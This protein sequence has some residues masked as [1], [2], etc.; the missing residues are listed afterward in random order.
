MEVS[1]PGDFPRLPCTPADQGRAPHSYNP[2]HVRRAY[3]FA[4]DEI[5]LVA[6]SAGTRVGPY[7]IVNAL[8]QGGMG[9]VYRAR[10]TRLDRSVAVKFIRTA[11]AHDPA[12]HERFAREARTLSG[13]NHPHI[14]TVY[15]VGT[16][17]SAAFIVMEYLEGETLAQR[18]G[19]GPLPLDLAVRYAVQIAD[20][21]ETA[22]AR[23]I[24][25]RDL[26][27]ANVVLSRSGAKLVDFG[28]AKLCDARP[29]PGEDL[30]TIT[31]R[32]QPVTSAGTMLGTLQYMAPEQ[33]EGNE[34]D[35][36]T[37]LFAFGALVYEMLTG[38]RAFEGA[39]YAATAAAIVHSEPPPLRSIRSDVP[40]PLDHLV[41]AC[42][43]K[44][45][46]TRWS[47]A[48]DAALVLHG[49]EAGQL[50]TAPA[51]ANSSVRLWIACT[52]AAAA[53]AAAAL[54]AIPTF[55]TSDQPR[56]VRYLSIVAPAN[57]ALSLGSAPQISPDGRLVAFVAVERSGQRKLYVRPLDRVSATALEGTEGAIQPFWAPDSGS[58]GFF[59][60]GRLKTI[61]TT[62]GPPRTLAAAP[63]PR[64]GTWNRDGVILFVPRPPGVLHQV[65]VQGGDATPVGT[66]PPAQCWFPSFLPDGRH[67]LCSS[68]DQSRRT[69]KVYVAS[70]DSQKTTPLVATS[71]AGAV[72]AAGHLFYRRE[73]ELVAQQFDPH[74]FTLSG[75]P[76]TVA[77]TVATDPL[78][79][80]TLF[81]ASAEG[82]VAYLARGSESRLVW[83]D[84]TG[85]E[86][87]VVGRPGNYNSLCLSSD[88]RRIF[89]DHADTSGDVDIWMFDVAAGTSS[90][91]TFDRAVDFYPV[92]SRDG[93]ELVF[94][95]LRTGPPSLFRQHSG[96]PGGEQL[97]LKAPEPLIPTQW[98]VDRRFLIH[99]RLTARSSWDVWAQPLS[100]DGKPFPVVETPHDEV[101]GTLSPDT[102]LLAYASNESGIVEIY[103]QPFPRGGARWQVSRGGGLDPQ[104]RQDGKQ[105]FFVSP[106][107]KLM[108]VDVNDE[109]GEVSFGPPRALFGVASVSWEA[110]GHAYVVAANGQRFLVN[111]LSESAAAAPIGIILNSTSIVQ[112]H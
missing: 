100:G 3:E 80:Q 57:T 50:S 59:A 22:H 42:L 97:L 94:A 108:V 51:G 34:A 4:G 74:R 35:A 40:P 11:M 106:D 62:G 91:L 9:E 55:R 89:V 112:Q 43:S 6:L 8:G 33:I 105:L 27:P 25:H 20:A 17:E 19:K 86:I 28:L 39:T 29:D 13:L 109:R 69:E 78:T 48:H 23:G 14:C 61:A 107:K 12:V 96:A 73:D 53:L 67:F 32:H 98:S 72:A 54:L 10:D 63:V 82:A 65:A 110:I 95:S 45:R 7:E 37:D 90:R 56:Q 47:S 84:A 1:R 85:N 21:L 38:R 26:K 66:V 102:R 36:R 41:N 44:D 5:P 64:G 18:L 68:L 92:C 24:I 70:L 77:A 60:N 93:R 16:H 76:V 83:M 75:A 46:D 103:V 87:G 104:W 49:I 81:S 101:D 99:G 71:A 2:A 58:L 52:V 30:P 31:A 111:R 79:Y 15:D 88:E